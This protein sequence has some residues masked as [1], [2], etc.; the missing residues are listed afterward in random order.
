VKQDDDQPHTASGELVAKSKWK[1]ENTQIKVFPG[2]YDVEL[3]RG[4]MSQVI[5][6]VDC[7]RANCQADAVI[8]TLKVNFEGMSAVHTSVR[9]ADEEDNVALGEEAGKLNWQ[10]NKA[11]IQVFPGIYDL[12]L[13]KGAAN[14]VVDKINCQIPATC[15]A[16]EITA[17][18]TAEFPGLQGVH[19]KILLVD[20][21]E[22]TATGE[23]VT[24][25]NY[26]K[27]QASLI[28]FRQIYDVQVEHQQVSVFDA[29]D[30]RSG[31]CSVLVEGNV[32]ARLINGDLNTAIADV[33]LY[34][35]EKMPDGT[36]KKIMQGVANENGKVHFS[37][38]G[39]KEGRI[40]VLKAYKP[41]EN[42]KSYYSAFITKE[43]PYKFVVTADGE[44][45]LDL[46]Q[47]E[48][49]I[50]TPK[51]GG[52]VPH[53]GFE[54]NGFASDNRA[55]D[56]VTV[57]VSDPIKGESTLTA[58]YT[59]A[60]GSWNLQVSDRLISV[61][62]T[63]TLTATAFDVVQ[64]QISS[65]VNVMVIKDKDGPQI[66]FT[67]HS[68][69]DEV[70]VT[71]F[72]LSGVVTDQTGVEKLTV[73]LVDPI[74]GTTLS[75]RELDVSSLSGAWTLVVDN[76]LM[77]LGQVVTLNFTATDISGNTSQRALKLNVVAV[78]FSAAHLINRITFGATPLLL[79]EVDS[80]GAQ[81][82]LTQQLNPSLINDS[83]FNSMLG[84]TNP[85]TK[86]ALQSWTLM[87]ML[88]SKK[89]LQEVMTWFWDNHFNTD[90]NT[91]RMNAAGV[92]MNDT[93]AYELAEN[94][95]FRANALGNFRNLLGVSAKSP[96]M[97]IYLDSISN[98]A[99]DSNE[100][101]TREV[102]E[103]HTMGVDGGFD[104]HEIHAGAEIFTGWHL[105]NGN[106]FFNAAQ[107]NN[108]A[109]TV[110]GVAIP[111]G[112]IEQ[113]EQFLDIIADHP[114]TASFICQ[115]LVTL[116][117]NDNPPTNLVTRCVSK[118]LQS[119]N[120]IDQI[121]Q[122]VDLILQSAEFYDPVNYRAKIKT[123][124]EFVVAAARNLDAVSNATDLVAPI[125]A[126]GIRLYE[127]PVPTGWSEIGEDWMN[128]SLLIER[129]KWVNRLARELP[130]GNNTTIDPLSFYPQYGFET[131]EGIVGFLIKLSLDNDVTDL[132]RQQANGILGVDG[133][134]LADP[135][136]EDRLRQ[137]SG[138][139]LSFPQ[140]Q[141]Q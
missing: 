115:K 93:V 49:A 102:L 6:Q 31:S 62:Q 42:R 130:N 91:S 21:V 84:T 82:Y 60:T 87:H 38:A 43:G 81:G 126:M 20:D 24:H 23:K 131:A 29:V 65:S 30:C 7:R 3:Q 64:N 99:A 73:S 106:F 54:V 112:G 120:D 57:T 100:N 135:D 110:L 45:E 76:N 26:K 9:L 51:D 134:D 2:I 139:V 1:K 39:I 70:P 136:A 37:L 140:Y 85:T 69:N 8:N 101:Y 121:A 67:S 108:T 137:L 18:V 5:D 74:L 127:N 71:G 128:A 10:K 32:Q 13:R 80:L 17:T 63:I 94:R 83:A 107:H 44:N 79:N 58:N 89:Q 86:Q 105:R 118:F 12:F 68:D 56:R 46:T 129:I 77:T 36:L 95:A 96:S 34:A 11:E 125:A 88:H 78:D 132:A 119:S 90:L 122:V 22:G 25:A 27:Q 117:V 124:V 50:S 98:V 103:L 72:L 109:H 141:F 59:Q 40:Y 19:T 97:L 138:S 15:E 41:F 28:A 61:D 104:H 53:L 116:L 4:A 16:N 14:F 35:Y 113:G 123:P 33:R 133:I 55:I 75:D 66:S 114:S 111:A 47:P 52:L 48:L 92:E